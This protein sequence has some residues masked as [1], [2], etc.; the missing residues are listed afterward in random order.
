MSLVLNILRDSTRPKWFTVFRLDNLL[1]E[2]PP[3][4]MKIFPH[5]RRRENLFNIC[6][7]YVR[8]YSLMLLCTHSIRISGE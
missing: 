8:V 2:I 6:F 5:G 3:P 7:A 4:E 1:R